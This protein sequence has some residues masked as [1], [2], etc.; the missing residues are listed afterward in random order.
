MTW[1]VMAALMLVTSLSSQS[2]AQQ[3][4]PDVSPQARAVL[5]AIAANEFAKVEDRF[6]P[7]M[8]AALPAGRLAALWASL[9]TQAGA[10]KH[11]GTEP[12][13]RRIADKQMVI[14]ACEFERT[15]VDVQFAFDS[16]GRISGLT[17]RPGAKPP[18]PYAVPSYANPSSFAEREITIGSEWALPA[19]V[20]VPTGPGPWPAVVLVH[21]SGPNDRDE[22]I[23]ANKPF[24]DLATGLASRGI[25]VLRYDKRTMVHGAKAMAV[26]ALTVRQE[27][28]EDVLEAVKALRAQPGVD[29]ARVF[30]LGHSLGGMLIPRIATADPTI[31]GLI[32]LAGAARPLEEAIEV[33]TRYLAMVD[34][35]ISP[36]EQDGI[37]QAAAVAARV[38]ALTAEDAQND[39]P[40]S[41]APGVVLAG[42]ARLRSALS[43]DAREIADADTARRTG[44]SGD[45]G[46]VREME[47]GTRLA[48]RRQ[49][50][51][52]SHAEPSLHRGHRTGLAR[53]DKVPGHVAEEVIRDIAT[54][55]LAKR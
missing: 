6:T 44:L 9:V 16:A 28:I 47:G 24:K 36:Q 26:K 17:F 27:V 22:T 48:A 30:V 43:G 1:L 39:R 51:Q 55:V 13:V 5:A 21:G 12:R 23:L 11:C 38:R 15:I 19:T 42:F 20:S 33:Q 4:P 50:P 14:T 34:G 52:L 54:W 3:T 31:A 10:L 41:G 25:A 2:S 53:R 18:V 40:I 29:P 8:T 46:R 7:E 45:D 35:T 32:V 49:V 37:A